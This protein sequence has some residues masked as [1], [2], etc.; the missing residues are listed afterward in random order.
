[1]NSYI[2]MELS[3]TNLGYSSLHRSCF[4]SKSLL[5]K[6]LIVLRKWK[7]NLHEMRFFKS[8]KCMQKY[9]YLMGYMRGLDEQKGLFYL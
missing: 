4:H 9:I 7:M 1:M 2:I 8:A 3:K 5:N 6:C